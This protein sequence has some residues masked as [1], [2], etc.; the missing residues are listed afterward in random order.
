MHDFPQDESYP[1]IFFRKENQFFA[2]TVTSAFRWL[3]RPE[4]VFHSKRGGLNS[5]VLHTAAG[6]QQQQRAR[7]VVNDGRLWGATRWDVVLLLHVRQ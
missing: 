6:P 1:L 7:R 4:P 5:R 2:R 3:E